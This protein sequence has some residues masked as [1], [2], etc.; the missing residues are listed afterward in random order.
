[1]AKNRASSLNSC[2]SF[3]K[4]DPDTSS[5][6]TYL[7]CFP[8]DS[9]EYSGKWPKAGLMRRGQCYQ[10]QTAGQI[11]NANESGSCAKTKMWLTPRASDTG[12]GENP[13][14]FIQRNAD[15]TEK[16]AGSLA[17]QVRHPQTWPT[18]NASDQKNRISTREAALRRQSSGKQVSLEA[19]VHLWPTPSA[20]DGKGGY[21]GGRIRNGKVSW[22]RLDVAVQYTDNSQK[23]GG[24][25][26]PTWVGWVMGFPIGWEGLKPLETPRFLWWRQVHGSFLSE[27]FGVENR[28]CIFA[29]SSNCMKRV[30][31]SSDCD[32]DGNCPC[33]FDYVEECQRP[34]PTE[35]DFEY[36]EINGVMLGRRLAT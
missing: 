14:T 16:C 22:D 26:N 10:R 4:Y 21:Q 25:L 24:Q 3:A 8:K 30:V 31:F 34:G 5:W 20:T 28:N 19:A 12:K 33:N 36:Q 13:E 27:C 29:D 23:T 35:D 17:A 32:E 2:E 6:R 9:T 15:R 7:D 18:P 11:T 1:M